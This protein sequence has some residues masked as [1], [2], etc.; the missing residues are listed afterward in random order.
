VPAE[1]GLALF[2]SQS[3]ETIDTLS[4]LRYAKTLD[5]KTAAVVNV[6]ESQM[7]READV[8]LRYLRRARDR[9]RLDQGVHDAARGA[10]ELDPGG[11]A[12]ARDE[13]AG[14][15]RTARGGAGRGAGAHR[16]GPGA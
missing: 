7:S 4:A 15:A 8:T 6:P 5:L 2:I 16:R 3:G 13:G 11:G 9:R 14:G 1:N 10:C 12:G